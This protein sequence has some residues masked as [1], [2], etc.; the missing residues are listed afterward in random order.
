MDS[1][2][3]RSVS[4]SSSRRKPSAQTGTTDGTTTPPSGPAQTKRSWRDVFWK[5]SFMNSKAGPTNKDPNV[6]AKSMSVDPMHPEVAEEQMRAMYPQW[7][8]QG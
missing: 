2:Q 8:N 7:R 1:K 3:S 6:R 5:S 4:T